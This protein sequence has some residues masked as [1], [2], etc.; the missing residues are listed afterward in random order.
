MFDVKTEEGVVTGRVNGVYMDAAVVGELAGLDVSLDHMHAF[1]GQRETRHA[2]LQMT[3]DMT[4]DI[5]RQ[6]V[7]LLAEKCG[8]PAFTA[9]EWAEIADML[10]HGT[11][12]SPA[13]NDASDAYAARIRAGL[14]V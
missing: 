13:T 3:L 6:L 1:D 11:R 9:R 8:M 2:R 4:P 12:R 14:E 7:V 10:E 5:M